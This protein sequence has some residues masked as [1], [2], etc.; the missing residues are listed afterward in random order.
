[1]RWARRSSGRDVRRAGE[2]VLPGQTVLRDGDRARSRRA[3]RARFARALAD[4]LR[5]PA[6]A[7]GARHRRRAARAARGAA[8]RRDP[9]HEH[10]HDLGA[11]VLR[12]RR[13]RPDRSRRRRRGSDA[14]GGRARRSTVWTSRSSAEAFRSAPTTTCARASPRSGVEGGVLGPRAEAGKPRVVRAPRR[15][16]RVRP[17]RQPGLRDGHVRAA[18]RACAARDARA[19]GACP[20]ASE[21][22]LDSDYSK[23]AGR[24]HAVRCRL[25]RARGRPAR[26]ADGPAGLARA[27]LDA[28]RRRPGDDPERRDRRA[29]GQPRG[30][31]V[32]ARV[33][34][35]VSAAQE[36]AVEVRLFAMLRERAGS[37]TLRAAPARRRDGRRRARPSRRRGRTAR[38]AARALAGLDGRQPRVR[39]GRRPCSCPATSSP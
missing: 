14:R 17:A 36:I 32:T 2:D 38:G 19:P 35:P 26:D 22:I 1:M 30:R 21:A 25:E 6:A 9:R 33:D 18:R 29:R 24:A 31:R 39:A 28:G 16:A 5:A 23:P 11:R 7:V 15:D 12:R 34:A 27:E 3:R 20:S 13:G 4:P 8:G 10:A 37:G